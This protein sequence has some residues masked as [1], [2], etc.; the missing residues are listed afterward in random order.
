FDANRD[1]FLERSEMRA[2]HREGGPE[3]R[4]HGKGEKGMCPMGGKAPNGDMMKEADTNRDGSVSLAEFNA[5]A[6]RKQAERS[7]EHEARRQAMFT[8]MDANRDGSISQAEATAMRT[9]KGEGRPPRVDPDT[10]QDKKI[11]LA[12]WL[13]R[14]DPLFERADANKDGQVTRDE[15]AAAMREGRGHKGRPGRGW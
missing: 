1:G 13:A 12:E 2:G 7:A 6:A 9:A 10:N 4:G 3:G 8:R 11:S 14:P 15:A 5:I